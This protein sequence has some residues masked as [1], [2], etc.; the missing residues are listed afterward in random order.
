MTINSKLQLKIDIR[1]V[2]SLT[3]LYFFAFLDRINLGNAMIYGLGTDLKLKGVESNLLVFIFFIPYVL[4][5]V[6]SL[7]NSVSLGGSVSNLSI[8]SMQYIGKSIP[9]LTADNTSAAGMD[10]ILTTN[11]G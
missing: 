4:F 1:V 8:V 11:D 3:F 7:R 2:G 6:S 5:E 10:A 9:F